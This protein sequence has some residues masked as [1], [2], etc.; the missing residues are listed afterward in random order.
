ML[1]QIFDNASNQYVKGPF[2][3]SFLNFLYFLWAGFDVFASPLLKL[4]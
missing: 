3:Y 4:H 2:V 1:L